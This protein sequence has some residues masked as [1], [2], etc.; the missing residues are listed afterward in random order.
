M[1]SE[2]TK[3]VD[4]ELRFLTCEPQE[5]YIFKMHACYLNAYRLYLV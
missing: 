5:A 1:R 3:L 4:M 2:V